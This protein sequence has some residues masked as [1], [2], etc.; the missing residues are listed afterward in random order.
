MDGNSFTILD[1]KE[2]NKK[3]QNHNL[4]MAQGI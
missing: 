3:N 1:E 2:N 4:I